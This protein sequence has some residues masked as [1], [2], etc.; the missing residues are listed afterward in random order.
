MKRILRN[1]IPFFI[2]LGIGLMLFSTNGWPGFLLIFSWIGGSITIGC[3]ISMNLKGKKKDLGRRIAM[4]LCAPIFLIFMGIMQK[5]NLQLE[6]TVF[7]ALLFIYT[8]Y[9]IRVLVHYSVAKIFGPFIWGRGFCGWA[10][11]TAAILEWLPIQEN[12]KLPAYPG[13]IR[14]AV[15]VFSLAWPALF[16]W[17]GYDWV[18]MHINSKGGNTWFG[19]GKTGALI[20]FLVGNGLYYLV[21][22]WL[23]FKYKKKRAFCKI[24]CPVSLVM[25]AQTTVALIQ[26][27]PSGN[28]CTSCGSCNRHCPMDVDV[29]SYISQ[30]KRIRSSECIQCGMCKNVCPRKAVI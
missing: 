17:M 27:K 20:W 19:F 5:E 29:M 7:Y 18:D 13:W 11:W 16:I 22:I 30:N 1:C 8:G 14:Y 28:E 21:G 3:L 15:F 2:G 23:A 26:P 12:R 9:F 10:C 24:V 6:E 25:K 4:L